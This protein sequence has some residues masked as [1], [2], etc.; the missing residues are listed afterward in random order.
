MSH[1]NNDSGSDGNNSVGRSA[2]IGPFFLLIQKKGGNPIPVQSVIPVQPGSSFRDPFPTPTPT[3][4]PNPLSGCSV[5]LSGPRIYNPNRPRL[6]R[7][8]S[9]DSPSASHRSTT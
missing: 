1:T 2:H 6:R 4:N 5:T 7:A 3:P 9:A 8:P